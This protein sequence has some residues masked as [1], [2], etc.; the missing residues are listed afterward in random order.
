MLVS[1]SIMILLSA[2]GLALLL[3]GPKQEPDK[4]P[5]GRADL[6]GMLFYSSCCMIVG[7]HVGLGWVSYMYVAS[8]ITIFLVAKSLEK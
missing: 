2:I 7:A 4:K 5:M 8:I 6:V 1:A 3:F